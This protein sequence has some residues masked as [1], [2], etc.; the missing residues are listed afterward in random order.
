MTIMTDGINDE[1]MGVAGNLKAA[2]ERAGLTAE[3]QPIMMLVLLGGRR[4][5]PGI[6]FGL[7]PDQYDAGEQLAAILS[8]SG[9]IPPGKRFQNYPDQHTGTF[10][11]YIGSTSH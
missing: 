4:P 1:T 10:N 7:S 9:F 3:V 6:S 5:S 2:L 11:I 8:T